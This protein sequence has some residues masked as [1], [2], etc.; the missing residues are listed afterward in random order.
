MET[1]QSEPE[2]LDPEDYPHSR[3]AQP[4]GLPQGWP[5]TL[6]FCCLGLAVAIYAAGTP[7]EWALRW[8]VKLSGTHELRARLGLLGVLLALSARGFG[9]LRKVVWHI[10]LYLVAWVALAEALC[11]T[12]PLASVGGFSA[13]LALL[14]VLAIGPYATASPAPEPGGEAEREQ[15]RRLIAHEDSDTLA[16]FAL[17]YDK[18][19]SFSADRRAVISY[20]VL[21]GV[22]VISGDPIGDRRS[23]PGAITAFLALTRLRGWRPAVL[24]AGPQARELWLAHGMHPIEIG[25]EVIVEVDKFSLS[26]RQMR[27]VRQ[28]VGRTARAG[29][30]TRF[31]RESELDPALARQLRRIHETWLDRGPGRE[32]GFAMNLDAMAQGRHQDALLAI[33]FAAEGYAVGFQRYLPAATAGREPVLSLDVMPRDP[34]APNGV[35][36][37]LIV[38]TI[39]YARQHGFRAVSLNFAAFRSILSRSDA[40]GEEGAAW[41]VRPTKRTIH[42]LDPLIQVESL[43]LFNAKFRPDW[44]PRTV[45]VRS[46]FDL[47]WF[48]VAALG[49]EFALPYDRR[50]AVRELIGPSTGGDD[51][52]S[53]DGDSNDDEDAP[54]AR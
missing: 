51:S 23:W 14:A 10:G 16:P 8:A 53:N 42:L 11:P 45:L 40:R 9:R 18:S 34:I 30:T 25:D 29:I 41:W 27:N 43:Y 1:L 33:A 4:G 2:Q 13:L 17:R 50:R 3:A 7:P 35:N 15:V 28:A 46:W 22:A 44:L 38:D 5:Y 20:R 36:E 37:R 12:T 48:G 24:A 52:N 54:A 32:H 26:G 39:E 31:L 21:A 19:Y 6:L 49:M 47:P